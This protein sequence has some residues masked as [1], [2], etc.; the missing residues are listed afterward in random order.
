MISHQ[1]PYQSP[2]EQ[3]PD[4]PQAHG[5]Q[6]PGSDWRKLLRGGLVSF[7]LTA[8]LIIV[9]V[10]LFSPH[11]TESR[12]TLEMTVVG[13]ILI[14]F[15]LGLILTPIGVYGYLMEAYRSRNPKL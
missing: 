4:A 12:V 13:M 5:P 11:P 8:A 10:I 1:N 15:V 6:A 2:H 14:S 3:S 7:A 9:L